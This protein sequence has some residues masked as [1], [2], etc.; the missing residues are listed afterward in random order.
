M[1]LLTKNVVYASVAIGFAVA[2]TLIRVILSDKPSAPIGPVLF[3]AAVMGVGAAFI[4]LGVA[5]MVAYS[6]NKMGYDRPP[7]FHGLDDGDEPP[8]DGGPISD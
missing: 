8:N 4:S 3:L 1:K 5:Y 7:I 2:G 6:R